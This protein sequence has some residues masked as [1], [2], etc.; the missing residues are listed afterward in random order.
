MI[1]SRPPVERIVLFQVLF[2]FLERDVR[3]EAVRR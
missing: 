1:H 3:G 2:V